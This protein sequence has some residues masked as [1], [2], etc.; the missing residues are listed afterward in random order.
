MKPRTVRRT[1]QIDDAGNKEECTSTIPGRCAVAAML[2]RCLLAPDY[3]V[4]FPDDEAGNAS[5]FLKFMQTAS[6]WKAKQQQ[7]AAAAPAAEPVQ[8]MAVD[9][10]DGEEEA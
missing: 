5:Q 2:T 9:S 7:A 6:A 4:I 10:A 8:A 3:D 1:R